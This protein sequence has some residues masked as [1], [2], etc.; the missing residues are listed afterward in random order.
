MVAGIYGLVHSGWIAVL[1]QAVSIIGG[2]GDDKV[3]EAVVGYDYDES[4][5]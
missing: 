3:A 5:P 1:Q 2:G 4:L